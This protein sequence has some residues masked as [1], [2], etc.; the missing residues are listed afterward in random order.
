MNWNDVETD[1]TQLGWKILGLSGATISKQ[2]VLPL[3][4]IKPSTQNTCV[5]TP[6]SPTNKTAGCILHMNFM[7]HPSSQTE[8]LRNI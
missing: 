3:C 8:Q 1:G 4:I 2:Y 7:H 5:L 6:P